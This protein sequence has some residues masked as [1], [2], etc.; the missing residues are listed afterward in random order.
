MTSDEVTKTTD[1]AALRRV[2][3][4]VGT[5][6]LTCNG[7]PIDHEY[8]ADL[9]GQI[10]EQRALGRS[11]ILVSSGAIQ[12]GVDALGLSARPRTIPQK[13]A[14][15]AVGQGQLMH[16]YSEA[17]ARNGIV[18]AQM[19]LTRDDL[20]DRARYLNARNT[21][22]SILRYGAVPIVN[23][24]DSVAVE[25]IRFGENDT[26]G[27]LV[28][29]LT[30]A[31][32]LLMLSDVDGLYDKDPGAFSDARLIPV[33]EKV[34]R[35]VEQRAGG[36]RT[37]VGTGGMTTKIRAAKMCTSIGIRTIIAHGRRPN[38]VKDALDGLAGTLFL[39]GQTAMRQRKRWIAFGVIPK[40]IVTVND[41]AK[42]RLVN[43]GKSLLPAGV[44][45]VSGQFRTGELVRLVD[46]DG[47][48]F[49][50]GFVNYAHDDLAKI[51][52]RHTVDIATVLGSK[53]YD[54]VVHRDNLVLDL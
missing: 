7:G 18:V 26:L 48:P 33:V 10:A 17:F 11:V 23:E 29:A 50:Q 35:A 20:R 22:A 6:T 1:P 27:A 52:G 4:K 12:A 32:V 46:T 19:L 3:I 25:E 28:A 8:L 30:E 39:P 36:A 40:G 41:G 2:V 9:A 54:E 34:D 31:D 21:F 53:P 14:A 47:N 51:M 24:N 15:A 49:A 5:S 43:G 44:T 13:Q 37:T 16:Y 45:G 38:V 42:D